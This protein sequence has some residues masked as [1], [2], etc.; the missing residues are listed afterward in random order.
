MEINWN[1]VLI[2]L[3]ISFTITQIVRNI[4]EAI[5]YKST[6]NSIVNKFLENG[7]QNEEK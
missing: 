2:S 3:I 6:A 5:K 1:I 4:T 7:D